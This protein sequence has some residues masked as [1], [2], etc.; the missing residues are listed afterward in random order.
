MK[1]IAILCSCLSIWAH[2]AL[3]LEDQV[4]Q[5]LV[6][7]FAGDTANDSAKK[8]V[9]DVGVG[10][11]VYYAFANGCTSHKQLAEISSDLQAMA[12][13]PLLIGIDQEGGRIAHLKDGF[14][15]FP[16]NGALGKIGSES[17]AYL[18]GRAI[19]QDLY[20]CGI[21]VNFAPVIDVNSNPK[22]PIIGN[23]SF[24][25]T[26][27]VVGKL[28]RAMIKGF[29]D[30]G[31]HA[32]VKH[33]PGHGDVVV[34]SHLALPVVSKSRKELDTTELAPFAQLL[35]EVS[36]VMSAHILFP[37]VDPMHCSSVS[38]VW[39]KRVLR[40]DLKFT[41]I[42]ITDSLQMKG[43]LAQTG[44]IEEAAIQAFEAG[45]DMILLAGDFRTD[46]EALI[47]EAFSVRSALVEAIQSGRVS[48]E[49]L[50]ESLT[51]ISR[52]KQKNLH[53]KSR[54][55]CTAIAEEIC[56]QSIIAMPE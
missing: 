50:Y 28:G 15:Q 19:G 47:E 34:D 13:I 43:V 35:P 8:L 40:T 33:F 24:G 3:T 18:T 46:N 23:R 32:C 20:D 10:G 51:R 52:F 14:A 56:S 16:G 55:D 29:H 25:D 49:R 9:Q 12:K 36:M 22:N 11:I 27:E 6:V 42:A 26:P 54:V 53:P 41:G 5:L 4:G 45:N 31:V 39:M 30:S 2:A 38:S 21:T 37:Q 17:A 44:S 48:K 1:F 7:H